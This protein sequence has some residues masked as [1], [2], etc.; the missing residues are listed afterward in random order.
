M[1]FYTA[2]LHEAITCCSKLR[3]ITWRRQDPSP[4]R[5]GN[6]KK[7]TSDHS[8]SVHRHRH[9]SI[10]YLFTVPLLVP[11]VSSTN[12]QKNNIKMVKQ[13]R[14]DTL[15][16]HERYF[17]VFNGNAGPALTSGASERRLTAAVRPNLSFVRHLCEQHASEVT[18]QA[19]MEDN[20]P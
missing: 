2:Q 6:T 12:Q 11:S 14:G 10:P 5:R 13:S 15:K 20:S 1:F 8:I 16:T 18:Q 9:I 4:Q 17:L 7:T 3:K 19:I